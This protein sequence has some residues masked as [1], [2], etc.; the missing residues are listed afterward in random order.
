MNSR[1]KGARG[2]REWSA[3]LREHGFRARRG[4]QYA[5]GPDS[6]DVL[7][8]DLPGIHFEVKR[9]ERLHLYDALAQ[10]VR[11][12]GDK[13]PVVA[14]RANDCEWV[15]IL[16]ADDVLGLLRETRLVRDASG[17]AA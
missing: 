11:E 2:E 6:P 5:G 10:A 7:C 9:T 13:L 4:V 3:K 17:E 1:Q 15:V 12:A 14:H 16:R 8:E